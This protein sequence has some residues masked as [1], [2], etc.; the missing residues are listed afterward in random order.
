MA[1]WEEFELGATTKRKVVQ[2]RLLDKQLEAKKEKREK[3]VGESKEDVFAFQCRANKLPPFVRGYR[4]A[5]VLKRQ[6][7]FDFCFHVLKGDL[8]PRE[9][10]LAVELEGFTMMRDKATGEWHMGGRHAS[11][12]GF[13]EDCVKYNTAALLGWTVLRFPHTEVAKG[14]AVQMTMRVLHR[15]GYR[16]PE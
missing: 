13:K 15:M 3:S 11:V 10:R 7:S 12:A 2:L 9:I 1:E 8:S 4:F 6:W 16:V 5:Q 14:T